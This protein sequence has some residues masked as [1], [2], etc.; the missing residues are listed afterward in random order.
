MI[1]DGGNTRAIGV[2]LVGLKF[3]HV[4][5]VGDFI[6]PISGDVFIV[7]DEECVGAFDAR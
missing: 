6:E 2:I 3:A 1:A 5:C 4:F 7:Y